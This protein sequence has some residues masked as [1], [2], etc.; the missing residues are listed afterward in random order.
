MADRKLILS[1]VVI[2]TLIV[3]FALV[4][5]LLPSDGATGFTTAVDNY[6]FP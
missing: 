4:L 2:I 5:F 6:T 1:L 3:V